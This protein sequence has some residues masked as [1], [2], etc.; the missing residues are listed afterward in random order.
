M[1]F[2]FIKLALILLSTLFLMANQSQARECSDVHPDAKLASDKGIDTYSVYPDFRPSPDAIPQTFNTKPGDCYISF[3]SGTRGAEGQDEDIAK[4][5]AF[6]GTELLN[7]VP[8][9]GSNV[10]SCLFRITG[11][12]GG[13]DIG[14][15]TPPPPEPAYTPP[16]PPSPTPPPVY[17]QPIQ[18]VHEV[19]RYVFK[20]CNYTGEKVR[21]AV[22]LRQRPEA[23]LVLY[24]FSYINDGQCFSTYI[25]RDSLDPSSLVYYHAQTI[26][27]TGT[28]TWNGDS[29]PIR[30]TRCVPKAGTTR[31]LSIPY[32]CKK[33][34]EKLVFVGER[35]KGD[36]TV[37]LT[38]ED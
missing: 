35:F 21:I 1:H 24:A 33:D 8:D 4:C 3:Y 27:G 7:F 19:K 2:R 13:E 20:I 23:D 26:G 6:G 28:I 25:F 37:E 22:I 38:K 36:Y 31:S 32:E 12:G 15:Y 18:P 11:D 34:D 17:S 5:K 10:N 29:S 16:T 9:M 14:N 30:T